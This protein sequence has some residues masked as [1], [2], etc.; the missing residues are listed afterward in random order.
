MATTTVPVST[1]LR[2]ERD[3]YVAALAAYQRAGG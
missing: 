1:V 3:G 2:S